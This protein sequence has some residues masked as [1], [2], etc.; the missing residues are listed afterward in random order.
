ADAKEGAE[1]NGPKGVAQ[2]IVS[3]HEPLRAHWQQD[4]RKR[5]SQACDNDR[6]R[7]PLPIARWRTRFGRIQE[8]G[9]ERIGGNGQKRYHSDSK[10]EERAPGRRINEKTDALDEEDR[11]GRPQGNR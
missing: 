8:D 6:N 5:L 2:L 1:E 4:R 10:D 9:A 7:S 11:C 3:R